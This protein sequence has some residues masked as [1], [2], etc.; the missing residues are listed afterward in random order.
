MIQWG[1][2]SDLLSRRSNVL[3]HN[4]SSRGTHLLLDNNGHMLQRLISWLICLVCV[5][6]N[7][8]TI[9][10]VTLYIKRRV[11]Y[12]IRWMDIFSFELNA[13]QVF[14][15]TNFLLIS[16]FDGSLKYIPRHFKC[17]KRLR[18]HF[19]HF[20]VK[21]NP[22][23]RFPFLIIRRPTW[24]T[25]RENSRTVISRNCRQFLVDFFFCF[26]IKVAVEPVL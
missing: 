23:K 21:R 10:C 26:V 12:I 14:S 8:N 7:W 18:L 3:C 13:N 20:V 1:E 17:I 6:K 16:L 9:V 15:S 24:M 22:T 11:H 19:I 2:K 4:Y 5:G 25:F